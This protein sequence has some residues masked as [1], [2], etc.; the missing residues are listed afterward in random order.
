[1]KCEHVI[2]LNRKLFLEFDFLV[3]K[4]D[5]RIKEAKLNV[6]FVSVVAEKT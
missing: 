6:Q 2:N 4:L 5:F 1:M 3:L